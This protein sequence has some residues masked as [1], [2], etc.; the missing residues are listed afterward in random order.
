[1]K[2]PHWLNFKISLST[3]LT[4]VKW[5]KKRKERIMC[6][7]WFHKPNPVPA[8]TPTPTPNPVVKK[9]A[10]LF[11]INNYP[12]TQNDLNGCLND[13]RDMT[14]TLNKLYPGEFEIKK[15]SDSQVTTD[16]Y[17][18][19]IEDAI[20]H[21]HPGAVVIIMADS[22][23]SGTITKFFNNFIENPHP[24]KNR[25][26]QNPNLP[27]RN[28]VA[29][30]FAKKNTSA[31]PMRW[32]TLS[33]CGEEQT[34]ADTYIAK[35]YHGAFTYYALKALQLGMTYRQWHK[36]IRVYLPNIDSGYDQIPGIEGP[37]NLLD[38]K[39]FDGEILI[40]HNSTHGT[41]DYDKDGDESDGY[42]EAIYLY[43]GMVIDDEINVL[44]Q[45]I[46]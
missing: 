5:F 23:F 28:R 12:G 2:I 35:E 33:G 8:P 18:L 36:A 44:L 11:A 20:A 15:F 27:I 32:I 22:C 46:P 43:D 29:N 7:K 6:F 9:R 38:R 19:Q 16:C 3:I 10:L 37:D 41:Q 4:I 31:T 24:T 14:D 17:K 30:Q 39:V 42:D 40:I 1:M 34:S 13:Q 21:L 25:F 45:K 26:Y